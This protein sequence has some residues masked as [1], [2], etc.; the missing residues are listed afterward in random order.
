MV[1]PDC[2]AD[3]LCLGLYSLLEGL[4]FLHSTARLAHGNLH[5]GSVFV[6]EQNAAW[7][8]A[9]LEHVGDESHLTNEVGTH[10]SPFHTWSAPVR[11]VRLSADKRR[12]AVGPL[13]Q[14]TGPLW[15]HAC[16]PS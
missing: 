3:E 6:S 16:P 11:P 7:Q 12:Q 2:D 13:K 1:L 15:R 4:D 14:P 8:L 9:H 10:H 5:L